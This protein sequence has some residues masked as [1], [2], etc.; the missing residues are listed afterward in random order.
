MGSVLKFSSFSEICKKR[1]FRT[2]NTPKPTEHE[3][4]FLKIFDF[5]KSSFA[6]LGVLWVRKALFLK[7]F[8]KFEKFRT[9][10]IPWAFSY[11]LYFMRYIRLK[12]PKN[13][14]YSPHSKNEQFWA[15]FGCCVL[16]CC[17]GPK[18]GP[19]TP[20]NF[21]AVDWVQEASSKKKASFL[22]IS[23]RYFGHFV[24]NFG[25]FEGL[26]TTKWPKFWPFLTKKQHLLKKF[27]KIFLII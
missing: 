7:I 18:N 8:E 15:N 27:F 12:F 11:D 17:R 24:Q 6:G 2:H 10:S 26:K 21:L 25:K 20:K 23:G 13:R 5:L 16:F 3:V 19:H 14:P 22:P 1:S 9:L 4:S